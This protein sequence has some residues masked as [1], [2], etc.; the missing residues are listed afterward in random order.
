[1]RVGLANVELSRLRSGLARYRT[2]LLR[3]SRTL[4]YKALH[5]HSTKTRMIIG[6]W[7]SFDLRLQ[8]PNQKKDT[9][10][11]PRPSLRAFISVISICPPLTPLLLLFPQLK[12][13]ACLRRRCRALRLLIVNCSPCPMLSL[14]SSA[15]LLPHHTAPWA[16]AGTD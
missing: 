10:P 14:D 13:G 9:L 3:P 12:V 6:H 8:T 16:I 11:L 1:M 15:R 2:S 4:S 5:L 7:H